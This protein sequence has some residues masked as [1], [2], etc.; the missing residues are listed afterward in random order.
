MTITFTWEQAIISLLVFVAIIALFVLMSVLIKLK[1]TLE[2]VDLILDDSK[3]I[4]GFA[5]DQTGKAEIIIN[6]ISDSVGAV[7]SNLSAS[8]GV[9]KNATAFINAATSL[10]GII[11][12][13]NA[14]AADEKNIKS[15]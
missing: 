4:S 14:E 1:K 2:K 13:K 3:K 12:S 5:A 9:I 6:G 10:V 15:K 8:K 11:K 7:V